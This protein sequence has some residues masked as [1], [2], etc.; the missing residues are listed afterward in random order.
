MFITEISHIH[1]II[2]GAQYCFIDCNTVVYRDIYC[3]TCDI[4]FYEAGCMT[5]DLGGDFNIIFIA[6]NVNFDCSVF[7]FCGIFN[8]CE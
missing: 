3:L 1:T 2:A 4:E 8:D 5:V 7:E 6:F